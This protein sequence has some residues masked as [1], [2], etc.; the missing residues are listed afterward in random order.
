[1]PAEEHIDF[2]DAR[3]SLISSSALLH[4]ECW[5]H[6]EGRLW[7]STC[8][9]HRASARASLRYGSRDYEQQICSIIG[10]FSYVFSTAHDYGIYESFLRMC[11]ARVYKYLLAFSHRL[12]VLEN[13]RRTLKIVVLVFFSQSCI[14]QSR[15]CAFHHNWVTI[16]VIGGEEERK[17]SIAAFLSLSRSSWALPSDDSLFLRFFHFSL[18]FSPTLTRSFTWSALVPSPTAFS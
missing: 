10:E 2:D 15:H 4:H 9:D 11:L 5:T 17:Q 8:I 12:F 6:H 3:A 13:K 16:V 1:M 14:I 7:Y 18:P